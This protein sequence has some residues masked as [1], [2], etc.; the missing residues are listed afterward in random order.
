MLT[1]LPWIS[2]LWDRASSWQLN[3]AR[4]TWCHL[5]FI[6]LFNA[7]HVSN[8]NTS[9]FRSLRLI[10][11]VSSRVVLLWY[12][13]CW[14]YVV[15]WLGWCGILMQPEAPL[16]LHNNTTHVTTQQISRKLLRMDVLTPET[17][18]ALN[19]EIKSKWHQVGLALFCLA[20]SLFRLSVIGWFFLVMKGDD[21][22][23]ILMKN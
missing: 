15:V 21:Y 18:W 1:D 23:F 3:K 4:P 9:I 22:F 20:L 17:C 5:L 16:S 11:C 14:C 10:C 2:R 13:V 8:V 19:N 6:S 12:D 7:Q